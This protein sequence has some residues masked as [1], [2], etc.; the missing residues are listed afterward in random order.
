MATRSRCLSLGR[1]E[2]QTLRFRKKQVG[3]PRFSK[4]VEVIRNATH[5]DRVEVFSVRI[6]SGVYPC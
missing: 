2:T 5:I 6:L 3:R 4:D 1:C